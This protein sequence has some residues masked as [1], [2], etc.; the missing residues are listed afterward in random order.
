MDDDARLIAQSRV[1]ADELPVVPLEA[2]SPVHARG[3]PHVMWSG[4]GDS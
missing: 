3:E 2:H 1:D 4:D